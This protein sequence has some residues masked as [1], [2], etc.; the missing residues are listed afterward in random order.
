MFYCLFF[1]IAF[2]CFV[3]LIFLLIP[4]NVI[5]FKFLSVTVSLLLE[6]QVFHYLF[7]FYSENVL[8]HFPPSPP[9]SGSLK[10]DLY[11]WHQPASLSSGCLLGSAYRETQQEN[12]G[13]EEC[14]GIYS[15]SL[16]P[17]VLISSLNI[18]QNSCQDS[19]LQMTF[20]LWFWYLLPLLHLSSLLLAL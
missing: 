20:S 12:G 16:L 9:C 4:M 1:I 8:I 18:D 11:Q 6:R 7:K 3:F 17:R 19:A 10:A 5:H 14:E 15:L 2:L 13:R